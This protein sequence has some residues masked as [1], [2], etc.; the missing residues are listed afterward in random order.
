M[1]ARGYFAR[2]RSHDAF[3]KLRAV[4]REV[5]HCIALESIGGSHPEGTIQVLVPLLSADMPTTA[6]LTPYMY[7]YNAS[8]EGPQPAARV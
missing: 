5:A 1:A 8:H 2:A 3:T 7:S 6:T 4:S